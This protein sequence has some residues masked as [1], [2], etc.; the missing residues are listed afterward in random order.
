MEKENSIH[1]VKSENDNY[2]IPSYL[3]NSYRL[4]GACL[5]NSQ[6]CTNF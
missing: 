1:G 6:V 2:A 3:V 4:C 5:K